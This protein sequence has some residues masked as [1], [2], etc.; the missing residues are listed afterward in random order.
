[1]K[2]VII[3]IVIV[4]ALVFFARKTRVD[5]YISTTVCHVQKEMKEQISTKFEIDR[6]RHEIAHLDG[7]VGNMIKP[8]AEYMAAIGRLRKDIAEQEAKIDEQ[9][10]SMLKLTKQLEG[11][12]KQVS[13]EGHNYGSERARRKLQRDFESCKRVETHLKGQ[14]KL[15]EAKETSLRGA[16]E[17]LAKV[18][19]KKREYEL[20]LAQLEADEEMLQVARVGAKLPLDDSRATKIEAD[21][22]QIEHRHQV[23]RHQV[24]LLNGELGQEIAPSSRTVPATVDLTAIRQYLEGTATTPSSKD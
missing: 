10:A 19:A 24:E 2:K 16:Q 22:A 8:I 21:L 11:N 15:L 23:Q 13:F 7:D 17:Q 12:P 5:S 14:V 6:V 3:A 18:I 4:A 1:M 9:K 20:R